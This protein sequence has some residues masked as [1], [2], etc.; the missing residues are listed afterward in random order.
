MEWEYGDREPHWTSA[1]LPFGRD[2]YG[3]EIRLPVHN[4][5]WL[6]GGLPG[7]GKSGGINTLLCGLAPLDNV[8]L[9]LIDRKLTEL[10]PWEKRASRVACELPEI[11]ELLDELLRVMR[12]RHKAMSDEGVR[13]LVPAPDHPL[14]VTVVDELA[15]L[16]LERGSQHR[17]DKIRYLTMLG[18]AAGMPLVMAA[19]RPTY[20]AVPTGIRDLCQIRVCYATSNAQM[21][22]V[23]LGDAHSAAHDIPGS[24]P[25]VC[26][27]LPETQRS[28]KQMR[29]Y[30]VSDDQVQ[31]TVKATADLAV[32]VL[33]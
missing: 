8:A 15:A 16:F 1:S 14:I 22:S 12:A 7:S 30:W 17:E 3:T 26:Y 20:E 13:V 24:E 29:T 21:S 9:C 31:E 19:Q 10:R 33:Y 32:R 28:P 11:D 23:I 5:N 27:V 2:A 6:L 25:G 18:R 4:R